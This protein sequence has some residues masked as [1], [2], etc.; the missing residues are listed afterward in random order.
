MRRVRFSIGIVGT[1]CL[2]VAAGAIGA[3]CR[4]PR[5]VRGRAEVARLARRAC[6]ADDMAACARLADAYSRGRGVA[7]DPV[8]AVA[9]AERACTRAP[10]RGCALLAAHYLTGAGVARDVDRAT[11]LADRQCAAGDMDGCAVRALLWTFDFAHHHRADAPALAT[12]V[13]LARRACDGRSALGC[14]TLAG[15]YL[16]GFDVDWDRD[17][18]RARALALYQ[19]SCDSEEQLGCRAL[20]EMFL[21]GEGRERDRNVAR[22][23]GVLRAE[24]DRG[25]LG[26]CASLGWTMILGADRWLNGWETPSQPGGG[27]DHRVVPLTPVETRG[28]SLVERACAG[29]ERAECGRLAR[30]WLSD[31][32]PREWA[33][34]VPLLGSLCESGNPSAC[35]ELGDVFLPSPFQQGASPA[36]P[37]ADPARALR[38]YERACAG[39]IGFQCL[40]LAERFA[41]GTQVTADPTR[42]TEFYLRACDALEHD[43]CARAARAYRDGAGVA[44]D[45]ERAA[46]LFQLPC[47]DSWSETCAELMALS[48]SPVVARVQRAAV[49]ALEAECRDDQ[50]SACAIAGELWSRNEGLPRDSA[51]A[52]VYLRRACPDSPAENDYRRNLCLGLGRAYRDGSVLERSD[53]RALGLFVRACQNGQ[54][55]AC[56]EILTLPAE[57]PGWPAAF[58]SVQESLGGPWCRRAY[59]VKARF[60]LAGRGVR[61]DPGLACE[62]FRSA[63]ADRELPYDCSEAARL[64]T[65]GSCPDPLPRENRLEL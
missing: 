29:G 43:G 34:A 20:G 10:P 11:T 19:R 56:G 62:M 54:C 26:V 64:Q 31:R 53:A 45:V 44:R 57:T 4:R 59:G 32:P 40:R 60:Y 38:N 51:R 37:A 18:D 63:C 22:G 13:A 55:E 8:Q 61:R 49:A 25:D 17:R 42:A 65:A 28:L 47:S 14:T 48:A 41:R 50:W 52:L 46:T 6:D 30:W 24:C 1:A 5:P 35:F 23:E 33:R 39:G 12:A 58:R 9:I 3:G 2:V 21:S 7:R 15:F 27:R 36:R 16:R